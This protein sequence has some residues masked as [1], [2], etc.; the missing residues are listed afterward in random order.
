MLVL[1]ALIL[2]SLT[3]YIFYKAK[4]FR[5]QRPMEKGWVAGKSSMALGAFVAFYGLN[6]LVAY[7]SSTVSL[8][9]GI[10]FLLIGAAYVYKGFRQYKYFLPL[11]IEEAE[12]SN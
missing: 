11:A 12:A 7:S 1:A 9:V 4:Y 6:Q 10:V 5:T 8:L 2:I 3:L